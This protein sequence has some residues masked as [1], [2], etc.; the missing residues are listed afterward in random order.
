MAL[1]IAS[2]LSPFAGA[3]FLAGLPLPGAL[4]AVC[5]QNVESKGMKD[6]LKSKCLTHENKFPF[7]GTVNRKL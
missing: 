3:Q 4:M 5:V 2:V 6:S 1:F 7:N